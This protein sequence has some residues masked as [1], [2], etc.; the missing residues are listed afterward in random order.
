M[1]VTCTGRDCCSASTCVRAKENPFRRATCDA[2]IA[3]ETRSSKTAANSMSPSLVV[4]VRVLYSCAVTCVYQLTDCIRSCSAAC[5]ICLT[6]EINTSSARLS[7]DHTQGQACKYA[8]VVT[9]ILSHA[10]RFNI[11]H[12]YTSQLCTNQTLKQERAS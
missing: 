12:M 7:D 2:V 10:Y 5:S 1:F 6:E 11:L 4:K 9:D 8:H 3:S